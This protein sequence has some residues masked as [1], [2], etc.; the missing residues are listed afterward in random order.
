MPLAFIAVVA[1][2]LVLNALAGG[3]TNSAE[4]KASIVDQVKNPKIEATY[5]VNSGN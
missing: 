1:G 3:A 4:I 5:D 2:G